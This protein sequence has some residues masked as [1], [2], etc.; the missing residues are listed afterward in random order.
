VLAQMA[1]EGKKSVEAFAFEDF[2]DVAASE[3]D[4]RVPVLTDLLVGLGVK[5][6]GGYQDAELAMSQA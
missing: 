6:W 1:T 4:D 3:D 5:V 2:Y